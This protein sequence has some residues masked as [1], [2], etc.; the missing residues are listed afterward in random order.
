M[1]WEEPKVSFLKGGRGSDCVG[2]LCEFGFYSNAVGGHR[3][4]VSRG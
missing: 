1:G 2:P 3:G 4:V